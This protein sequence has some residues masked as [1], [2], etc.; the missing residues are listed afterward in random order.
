MEEEGEKHDLNLN[1]AKFELININK[2]QR[3]QFRD[4]TLVPVV[5]EAKYL[6]C[7]LNDKGDSKREVNRRISDGFFT[8]KK[9]LDFGS[10][11]IAR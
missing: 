5:N 9:Y 10:T 8:S 2:K 3:I 4:G 11:V 7:M 6:G 1:K